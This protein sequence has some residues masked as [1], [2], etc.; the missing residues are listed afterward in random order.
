MNDMFLDDIKDVSVTT[1]TRHIHKCLYT[2]IL[3]TQL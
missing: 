2:L 1:Y 3:M